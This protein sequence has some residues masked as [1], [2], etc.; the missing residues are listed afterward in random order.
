MACVLLYR[1]LGGV[2][3]DVV[4]AEKHESE[5]EIATHPVERSADIADHAWRKPRKVTIE[6][7][8]GQGRGVG[9][10]Q[11]LLRIQEKPQLFTLVTGLK[12]YPDMMLQTLTAERNSEY[13]RVLK[14]EAGCQEIIRVS[15]QTTSGQG[16]SG[17]GNSS[18]EKASSNVNRGEVQARQVSGSSLTTSQSDAILSNAVAP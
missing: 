14:F 10:Y 11:A 7:I 15:T 13:A 12:V 1:D 8:V 9:A 17:S 16:G 18:T 5:M 2:P 6:G 3:I 4:I